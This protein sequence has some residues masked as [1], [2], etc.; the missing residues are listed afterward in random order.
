MRTLLISLTALFSLTGCTALHKAL[1]EKDIS[2]LPVRSIETQYV[3]SAA[4]CPGAS[5]PLVVVAT[6]ED[7][8]LERS[9][10]AGTGDGSISWDGLQVVP[11]NARVVRE[12]V[13][14]LLP[15][16]A[17]YLDQPAIVQVSVRSNPQLKHAVTLPVTLGCPYAANFGGDSG[18]KG[19]D[20]SKGENGPDG[21]S[22]TST[23]SHARAGGHGAD[24]ANGGSGRHGEAGR[25]AGAVDV[26]VT[27]SSL[28]TPARPL[29]EVRARSL[30]DGANK[31]FLVDPAGGSVTV[32]ANGGSGGRGGN[33]GKGGDGGRGGTGA[34]NGN[35]GHGGNGG[36]AGD[37]ADGGDGGTFTLTV[38]PAAKPY[39]NAIV[40]EN[41]GGKGGKG[42]EPGKGGS[43]GNA[44]SGGA[45][46]RDGVASRVNGRDGRD[47][48]HGPPARIVEKQVLPSSA[49]T[50]FN[51]H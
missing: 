10:G 18:R 49:T 48:R 15:D 4:V 39:L 2:S 38:D 44:F 23:G 30:T 27:L 32:R 51:V 22:E 36:D 5:V 26:E 20:G 12:G 47:G 8:T 21:K 35:G 17:R 42:G 45:K 28:S 25:H 29:L 16:P 50:A 13:V 41:R 46:G 40:L 33:G 34:P 14:Q 43:G 9:A 11:T 7:G 3:S 1:F 19:E 37:G 6:L 24:G 31:I